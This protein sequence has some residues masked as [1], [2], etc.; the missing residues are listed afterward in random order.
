MAKKRP[1]KVRQPGPQPTT[2]EFSNGQRWNIL[3]LDPAQSCGWAYTRGKWGVQRFVKRPWRHP[4]AHYLDFRSWLSGCIGALQIT[5]IAYEAALASGGFGSGHRKEW[6]GIINAVAAEHDIPTIS[7][8]PSQLK[9]YATGDGGK[10]TDRE[11]MR[12]ALASRFGLELPADDH[13][14][15]AA[16]W[17]LSW[18]TAQA[19]AGL[20]TRTWS[21]FPE[22]RGCQGRESVCNRCCERFSGGLAC[23]RCGFVQSRLEA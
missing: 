23:P 1:K 2:P 3:A 6:E 18:A 4:Y 17:V 11:A 21:G 14:A 8:F 22:G 20:I 5:A 10:K 13:D 9:K 15:V 12:V 16:I 19:Q 7:V